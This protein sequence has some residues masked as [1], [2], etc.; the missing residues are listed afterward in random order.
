MAA[1]V[2]AQMD[3]GGKATAAAIFGDQYRDLASEWRSLY[4]SSSIAQQKIECFVA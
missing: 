1:I 4:H 3:Y 2:D